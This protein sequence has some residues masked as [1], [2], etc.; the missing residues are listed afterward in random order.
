MAVPQIIYGLGSKLSWENGAA[1]VST[2]EAAF[3][4]TLRGGGTNANRLVNWIRETSIAHIDNLQIIFNVANTAVVAYLATRL[5]EKICAQ[6]TLTILENNDLD[7]ALKSVLI[8]TGVGAVT[9]GVMLINRFSP[10]LAPPHQKGNVE[11]G[12]R[13]SAQQKIAKVLHTSKLVLNLTLAFFVKNRLWLGISIATSGYSLLKNIEFKWLTFSRAFPGRLGPI[14]EIKATYH[15]LALP[16]DKATAEEKCSICLEQQTD[17]AF[18]A[19]H[20]FHKGCIATT[21]STNSGQFIDQSNI[22]KIETKH[23]TNGVHTRTTYSYAVRIPESNLPSCPECRTIPLQN[24][25]DIEVTDRLDGKIK[26]SV[27]IERPTDRQYVFEYL[28]AAYNTAQAGLAFLQTY[29]EF[30]GTIYKIQK[31]ML[32]TDLIGYG[33]TVYYLTTR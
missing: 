9:L 29:P 28:Y 17:M 20:V 26:A 12:E 7:W 14:T 3:Y 2:A 23:Y 24:S 1:A 6:F 4:A 33:L 10:P 22:K 30:A 21:V 18:C 16:L 19:N 13:L 31:V 11:I 8:V 32:A 15:M 27:T 25:C 5:D